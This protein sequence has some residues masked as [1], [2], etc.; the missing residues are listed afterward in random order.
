MGNLQV[1]SGNQVLDLGIISRMATAINELQDDVQTKNAKVYTGT[2]IPAADTQTTRLSIVTQYVRVDLDSKNLKVSKTIK[3]GKTF[4]HVPV[5]TVTPALV[6]S[7]SKINT[8]NVSVI[9][10]RASESE[11]DIVVVST[12]VTA[13]IGVN[14]I[15]IGVL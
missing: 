4:A 5:V 11:I 12:S 6:T 13:T 15:A 7:I 1:P 9:I 2:A 8:P 14:I 10:T 3:L